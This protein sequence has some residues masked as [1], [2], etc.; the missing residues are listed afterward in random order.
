[1]ASMMSNLIEYIAKSLVD[2]PDEVR[3]TEHDDHGRIIIHLDVA[4]D[5]IGRVIGRDGRIATA[6]RSLIKVAAIRE[7]VRVGLEIGD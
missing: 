1:M 4:D 5:D 7:D 2:E 3:V 6:M